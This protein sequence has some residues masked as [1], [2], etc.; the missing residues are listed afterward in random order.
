MPKCT[1]LIRNVE[2]ADGSGRSPEIADVAIDQDRIVAIG[3][4]QDYV[5]DN[6]FDGE[7]K[8]L[9][10]RFHRRPYP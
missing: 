7:G 10:P 4:L 5:A 9:A 2:V 3:E 1:T 6:L 8:V